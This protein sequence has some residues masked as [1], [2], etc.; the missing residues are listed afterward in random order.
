MCRYRD[1][2]SMTIN[3]RDSIVTSDP[4]SCFNLLTWNFQGM[5]QWDV[6]VY[7]YMYIYILYIYIH[8]YATPPRSAFQALL[9]FCQPLIYS[10]ARALQAFKA[11]PG[12]YC[13]WLVR[14]SSHSA[15]LP[16]FSHVSIDGS[17]PFPVYFHIFHSWDRLGTQ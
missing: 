2:Y 14:G 6:Y 3:N 7:I 9:S 13:T 17:I 4:W 12:T 1:I 15:F 16:D 11:E 8:T 5:L 10:H